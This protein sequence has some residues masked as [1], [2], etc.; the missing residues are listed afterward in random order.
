MCADSDLVVCAWGVHG[1]YLKR[2]DAVKQM[3]RE[4]GHQLWCLGT[5]SSGEPRHPL[6]VASG[7]PF[8]ELR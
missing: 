2:G 3:L 6:Y 8:Q 1:D 5:T 7:T 4:R